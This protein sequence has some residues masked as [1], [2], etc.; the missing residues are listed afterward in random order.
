ME[1]IQL[2]EKFSA[3]A[4]EVSGSDYHKHQLAVKEHEAKLLKK[5]AK[6]AQYQ[7]GHDEY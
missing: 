7:A 2:I 1:V 5:I 4:E 6:E 3:D